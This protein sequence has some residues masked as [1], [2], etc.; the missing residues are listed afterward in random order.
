MSG[1]LFLKVSGRK[2]DMGK[3]VLFGAGMTGTAAVNYF[4]K[5]NI[6]AIIDNNPNKVGTIFE[7]IEVISFD[8]YLNKYMDLQIIISLYSS[9]YYEVLKPKFPRQLYLDWCRHFHSH[10]LENILL[11]G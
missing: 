2:S 7:G 3:Y 8:T 4:G 1:F 9:H 10:G 5:E 6:V 11:S